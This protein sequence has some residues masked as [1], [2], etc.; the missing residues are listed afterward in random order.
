M[1]SV[2]VPCFNEKNTL[3]LIINKVNS[4]NID[5]EIIVVDDGSDQETKQLVQNLSK[6]GVKVI[7]HDRNKGKGAAVKTA[8]A[9]AKGDIVIIQDADLEYDPADYYNLLEPIINGKA[10]VVYGSRFTGTQPRK[11]FSFF[12]YF[13]NKSL[14]LISN[15]FTNLNLTDMETGYKAFKS[16]II[17]NIDLKEKG[18]GFEPEITMKLAKAHHIFY[19]VGIS[20]YGRDYSQG[21]KIKWKDGIRAIW[22]IVKYRFFN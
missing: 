22:C 6:D 4:V 19:E 8:L 16:D 21:K 14:T 20:Y 10:D 9:Q 3:P 15:T 13:C 1:I 5:K 18:F 11:V 17:K 2:I 12:H 7:F